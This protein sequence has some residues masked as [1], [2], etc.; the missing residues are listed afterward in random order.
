MGAALSVE[1]LVCGSLNMDLVARVGHLPRPGET[2]AGRSLQRLP[3]GKG[4]NQAVAAARMGATVAMIGARGDDEDGAVLA[5]LL[6]EEGVDARGVC[7]RETRTQPAAHTGLAQVIVAA[8]GENSIVVHGGANQTLTSDEVRSGFVS[9]TTPASAGARNAAVP[10]IALA[11]L[12]TPLT[13]VAA[14]LEAARAAGARTI[15]N[16]AP[17]S[18]AALPLL[19]EADIVVLNETELTV[20]STAPAH[21]TGAEGVR[22]GCVIDAAM[23]LLQGHCRAVIVTLGAE[24]AWLVTVDDVQHFPAPAVTVVDTTGAG[25]CFCGVL[26]AGLAGGLALEAAVARAVSA[27]SLAVTQEGAAV[28][29]PRGSPV[30]SEEQIG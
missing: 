20:F 8:D 9:A 30:R 16:P 10:Q 19:G 3:G 23:P 17:A 2:V 26:A 21:D 28:S 14:F 11:Q 25:D 13:A 6:A 5:A 1:V 4:V 22:F 7:V 27:A 12:E 18:D 15:L 24:G 29:M